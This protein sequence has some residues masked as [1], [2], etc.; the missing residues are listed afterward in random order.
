[1]RRLI[2]SIPFFYNISLRLKHWH[3]SRLGK[4]GVTAYLNNSDSK[5]LQLGAGM[6][7][8]PGWLNTDYF[9]R[10]G[11]YFLDVTRRFTIPDNAFNYVFSE[12]HVEHISYQNARFMLKEI[13]RIL[14]PGGVL[15]LTTPDLNKYIYAYI[16]NDYQL[17]LVKQHVD[18]WI[19]TGFAYAKTYIPATADYR[20]HFINDIFLNYEHRF[21]YD[22]QALITILEEAGFQNVHQIDYSGE[23][24]SVFLNIESH[25]SE[26]D[27]MFTL[28][29]KGQKP[30]F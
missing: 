10:P 18:N 17:P 16:N 20:A 4:K 5:K 19:Y 25:T 24:D 8:L 3:L 6:N 14:Q 13:F 30:N 29:V 26:F 7:E 1:M 28:A 11:I 2:R 9:A 15:K 21:I 23:N 12:H 27:R 22:A